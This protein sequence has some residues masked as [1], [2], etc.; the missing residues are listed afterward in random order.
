MTFEIPDEDT[1]IRRFDELHE[2]GTLLYD[3]SARPLTH[4]YSPYLVVFMIT[5]AFT[6]KPDYGGAISTNHPS[7]LRPGSDIDTT[8][9]EIAAL[10]STHV[11]SFNKFAVFRPHLLM[12][13]ADGFRRQTSNLDLDDLRASW[14]VL[15]Q[16]P[17][18]SRWAAIYNCSVDGGCSRLHKHMQ[19]FPLASL[20]G[21]PG[22]AP[23]LNE[24]FEAA[25]LPFVVLRSKIAPD[26]T[27]D[28]VFAVYEKF[29]DAARRRLGQHQQQHG[30]GG[31]EAVTCP[32]NVVLT[33][34]YL[35]VIP[36]RVGYLD[37]LGA[38]AMGMMGLFPVSSQDLYQRWL[39]AGPIDVLS[40]MGVA[41]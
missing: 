20:A 39:A 27:A 17:T 36:R 2:A 34:D 33:R 38:N 19:F 21:T 8:G 28:D 22:V 16:L 4:V 12:V 6:K 5:S 9:F 30:G 13:T 11:L 35:V 24:S 1:L 14:A 37:G 40:L 41:K 29:I 23:F 18:K 10:G 26:A 25:Q 32:H 7:R 31:E 15:R 3:D